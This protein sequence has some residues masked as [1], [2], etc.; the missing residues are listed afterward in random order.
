M[1]LFALALGLFWASS[2]PVRAETQAE[3]I[4]SLTRMP[5]REVTVFK[6]GHAFV[7]QEGRVPVDARG[8]VVL[9]RLPVPVLG[10]F[11][12]Y[13]AERDVKLSA[14]TASRRRVSGEQT[15]IDVRG[16]LEANP[17]AMVELV[18]VDGKTVSGRLKGL[19]SRPVEELRGL[20]GATDRDLVPVKGAVVLLETGQGVLALPI[21]RVRSVSFKGTPTARF[22]NESFKN[23][24]TLG[25]VWPQGR[26]RREI[27]VGMAYVQKGLRWIP[28]Y[29]VTIGGAGKARVQLQATLVNEL[30]DLEDIVVNLVVGVPTF[31]FKDMVDPMAL[32]ETMARLGSAFDGQS[33][34]GYA[35]SNA[36][37][38]Q[39]ADMEGSRMRQENFRGSDLAPSLGPEVAGSEKDEDLF[40]FTIKGVT[41]KKGER[42][43]LPVTEYELAYRDV[44]VLDLP[45]A[46]PAEV[47]ANASD[48]QQREVARLLAAP[49]FTHV[50]RLTNSSHEPLTTAPALIGSEDRVLGQGMMTYTAPGADCDLALTT[51]V[52]IKVTKRD[53][54]TARVPGALTVDGSS[55][56][57]VDLQGNI[58]ITNRRD[59]AVDIEVKRSILG[60]ADQAG[61]L[62]KV[63]M[64]NAYEEGGAA[65]QPPWWGW[66]GWPGWW[67]AVNG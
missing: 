45:F 65:A 50:L 12:P 22:A 6:D 26:P 47:R 10:T 63:A 48:E 4:A 20:E 46:P 39:T 59:Q 21:E 37:M 2:A 53:R 64:V 31:R 5:V 18:D 1:R 41:L 15:A 56:L 16:L 61:Q 38:S 66:Y 3:P 49:H 32:Q 8:T 51:A 9:D 23:L 54:E 14:V 11:W 36:I 13:S 57:R 40:I 29:R 60:H 19:P 33:V 24:L 67:G 30:T 44:Y 7:V 52:D 42:M 28:S 62:G 25:F 58:A 35:L 34:G 55:Y 27:E 17:G 43:V